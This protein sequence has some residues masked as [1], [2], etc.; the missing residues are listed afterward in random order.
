MW[1]THG[2][3]VF[4]HESPYGQGAFLLPRLSTA[5]PD[6]PNTASSAC[7]IRGLAA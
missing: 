6:N 5:K 7:G 4:Y 3:R 1:G 2:M